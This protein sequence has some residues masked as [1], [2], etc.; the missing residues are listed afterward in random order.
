M[1]DNPD[2]SSVA[3]LVGEPARGRM[4]TA[5]MEGRALTA[6]E[7]ALEGG[8]APSTASSHLERLARGG[9]VTMA[10]Q[11]RHRY[12]RI[13]GPDVAAALEGLM[14]IAPSGPRVID[15]SGSVDEALRHARVC[16]DHLAGEAG[17][18]L[19]ESLSERKW[20]RCSRH[21]IAITTEGQE[22]FRRLGVD[23]EALRGERRPLCR[24]C[25]D[26]SERR[27]HLAGALGAAL[28]DRLLALRWARREAGTRALAFSARGAAFLETLQPP[29]PSTLRATL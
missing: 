26:W 24:P 14:A 22:W 5:L 17:V 18:R 2:V 1:D 9:L 6:T 15:R 10:R 25:L 7:L 16:Y 4:L 28:L 27:F 12:F 8:V 19:L 13:A 20:V 11:G 21:G 23:V 29:G 3:A